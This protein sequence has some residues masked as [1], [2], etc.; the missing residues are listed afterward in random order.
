LV[1]EWPVTKTRSKSRSR[2][3][4]HRPAGP[5]LRPVEDQNRELLADCRHHLGGQCGPRGMVL[6]LLHV[7]AWQVRQP[8]FW[9]RC[10]ERK[11]LPGRDICHGFGLRGSELKANFCGPVRFEPHN[12]A[13][14]PSIVLNGRHQES[15]LASPGSV[16]SPLPLA[17][18][19]FLIP[20][21]GELSRA[22]P[23]DS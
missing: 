17:Q 4:S 1:Q 5:P 14:R 21:S 9:A 10:P 18:A 19:S 3:V 8:P 7:S 22:F 23:W 2:G 12:G 16:G 11:G 20:Q 6:S 15:A 13:I